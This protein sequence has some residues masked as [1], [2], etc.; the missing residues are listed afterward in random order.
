M[1]LLTVSTKRLACALALLPALLPAQLAAAQDPPKPTP[2]TPGQ[3]KKPDGK[4]GETK[5][6]DTP[7]PKPGTPK[8]Y[9]DVITA[10]AKS[11]PGLFTVHR[12]EE[13]YYFEIPTDKLNRDM[14]WT[15]EIAQ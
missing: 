9:K 2:P 4:P 8:P 13:K 14:L 15:T 3:E 1:S 12:V 6:V 7:K 10:E 11:D 5:P